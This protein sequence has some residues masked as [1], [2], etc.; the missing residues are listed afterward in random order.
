MVLTK[1]IMTVLKRMIGVSIGRI[2]RN[3]IVAVTTQDGSRLTSGN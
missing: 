3:I 2:K 1:A